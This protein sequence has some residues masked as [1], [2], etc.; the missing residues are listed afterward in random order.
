MGL[1][2]AIRAGLAAG[3]LRLG[4]R[5]SFG[6]GGRL[7][8]AGALGLPQLTAQAFDLGFESGDTAPEVGDESIAC[9][10]A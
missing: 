2:A 7:A 4:P 5:P 1:G 9:A 8:L 10:A 6:E 3:P